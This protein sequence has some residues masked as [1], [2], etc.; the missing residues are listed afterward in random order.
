MV[1]IKRARQVIDDI[2]DSIAIERRDHK[3]VREHACL[4]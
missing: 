4:V 2:V 3:Y 1:L